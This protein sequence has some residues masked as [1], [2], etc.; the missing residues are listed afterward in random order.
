MLIFIAA[1]K[2]SINNSNFHQSLNNIVDEVK[3]SL[4]CQNWDIQPELEGL[5]IYDNDVVREKSD[6]QI[7]NSFYEIGTEVF[8]VLCV[9]LSSKINS[10]DVFIFVALQSNQILLPRMPP[11]NLLELL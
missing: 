10:H 5:W 3:E 11:Q 7:L 1:E 6:W 2:I 8:Q 9:S 4:D